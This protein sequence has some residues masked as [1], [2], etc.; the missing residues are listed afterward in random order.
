MVPMTKLPPTTK[1]PKLEMISLTASGPLWPSLNIIR[2]VAMF[3]ERRKSVMMRMSV[4]NV[5]RSV[6]FGT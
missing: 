2:V 3:S 4:G 1:F 6:G 5:L